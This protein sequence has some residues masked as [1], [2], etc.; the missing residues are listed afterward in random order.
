MER[1]SRPISYTIL[2]QSRSHVSLSSAPSKSAEPV[3]PIRDLLSVD[4]Y[5]MPTSHPDIPHSSIDIP[6][7]S[8][9]APPPFVDS[10][11]VSAYVPVGPSFALWDR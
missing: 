10:I 1:V 9:S 11:S 4:P 2:S 7:S 8:T 3:D 5:D 6:S